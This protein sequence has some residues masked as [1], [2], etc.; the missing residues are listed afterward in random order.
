M[1]VPFS[2][3]PASIRHRVLVVMALSVLGISASGVLVRLMEGIGPWTLAGWRTL[4]TALLLSPA[5][6]AHRSR[7]SRADVRATV[8]AGVFLGLHFGFWFWSL[9]LTTVMRS[10]VLVALVP[11]WT[12]LI[13]WGL[14]WGRPSGRFWIGVGLAAA[15]VA[16]MQGQS[17]AGGNWQGD[18]LALLGGVLW[19]GYFLIGRSVRQRVPV[20]AYMGVVCAA[21]AAMLLPAA[22]VLDPPLVGFSTQTWVLVGLAVLGP[23]LLGH[24][25]ANYAVKYLP[26]ST[27]STAM[28]LEPLGATALAWV[29]LG[30][31]VPAR[32]FLGAAVVMAGVLVAT[33]K[34]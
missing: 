13:E 9:S 27:V 18:A 21:A 33:R 25:G 10:T 34:R 22:A 29:V 5:I 19:A 28:L 1:S 31:A 16:W 11:V 3:Q 20:T 15:G 6:V 17:W 24:Q 7:M 32:A 14:G 4:G 2:E 30:E 12:G 8:L 26:A 23:Q